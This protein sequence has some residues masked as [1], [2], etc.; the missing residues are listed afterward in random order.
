MTNKFSFQ[1]DMTVDFKDKIASLVRSKLRDMNNGDP[2]DLFVE[3][4]VTMVSNSKTMSDISN[5]LKEF[6][7]SD[8]AIEFTDE[9]GIQ[10]QYMV[11]EQAEMKTLKLL[12]SKV[13]ID[14]PETNSR[15]LLKSALQQSSSPSTKEAATLHINP[16]IQLNK[17]NSNC[18]PHDQVLHVAHVPQKR[19]VYMVD[20]APT[21]GCIKLL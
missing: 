3:Y 17:I 6:M 19:K 13:K 5:E 15:R 10:I 18:K 1:G 2:D 20:S 7:P 8:A 9:L 16:E 21:A 14:Q 4:I 11:Q 12:A